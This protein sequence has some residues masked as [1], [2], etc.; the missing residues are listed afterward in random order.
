MGM[1]V[2]CSPVIPSTTAIAARETPTGT[3]APIL[4]SAEE[5]P[6]QMIDP[7]SY[8]PSTITTS[9]PTP[10]VNVSEALPSTTPTKG[11]FTHVF[12]VQPVE[13]VSY[14]PG[15]HGYPAVDIFA[16][17]GTAF[18]AVT[19]G[20]VDFIS[21]KDLWDPAEDD[22]AT[23]GGLAVAIIGNDGVRYYGSHLS[24]VE[25]SLTVGMHVQAG[26]TLGK[27]GNS[28][29]A[30]HV[31]PH[32]HFGISRPTHPEDWIVRRGEVDP[33]PYLQDWERGE[34]SLPILPADGTE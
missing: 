21:S 9:I 6:T 32:L 22:P 15:H 24:A 29:N 28:G 26:Q 5:M 30:R 3:I 8:S 18:V 20:V 19:N 14:A 11:I 13:A 25:P 12:P 23:R 17:E 10:N 1:T 2:A 34:D 7:T 16:P 33:Y 27:V 4:L 31:A